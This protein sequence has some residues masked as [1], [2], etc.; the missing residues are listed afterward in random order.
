MV[1]IQHPTCRSAMLCPIGRIL[2]MKLAFMTRAFVLGA[3]LGL[4]RAGR[5]FET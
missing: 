2:V 5:D 4:W 1:T 3:S